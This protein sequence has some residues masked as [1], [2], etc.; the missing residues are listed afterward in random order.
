MALISIVVPVYNNARSLQD[1][2]E[3][4]QQLA[5]QNAG[6]SFEFV[7]VDDGSQDESYTVLLA[8]AQREPCLRIVKLSRNFGSNAAMM[9]GLSQSRGQAI[10]AR[11]GHPA[12]AHRQRVET[13]PRAFQAVTQCDR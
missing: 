1:L 7:F 4:F 13:R 11:N 9:A 3:R 5:A 6:D 2:L 12:G 8:M 10:A